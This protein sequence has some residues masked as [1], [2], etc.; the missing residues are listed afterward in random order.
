[1]QDGATVQNASV[2]LAEN[3]VSVKVHSRATCTEDLG[4]PACISVMD[5]T[6]TEAFKLDSTSAF[7]AGTCTVNVQSSAAVAARAISTSSTKFSK[8][9]AMGGVQGNTASLNMVA[10]CPSISD[11]W[12]NAMPT[13][14]I[15]AGC[16]SSGASRSG[17]YSV[18]PGSSGV[19]TFCGNNTLGG[20]KVT[21]NPGLYIVKDGALTLSAS[22]VIANGVSFYFPSTNST[23]V[24]KGKE[25]NSLK[26]PTSG[27]Y[28]GLLMFSGPEAGTRS[29]TIGS[30]DKTTMEG[31][32]H[33]PNWNLTLDST[34]DWSTVA[35]SKLNI[36]TKTFF[37]KSI[38][39]LNLKP[40]TTVSPSGSTDKVVYLDQ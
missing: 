18:T 22:T 20:S 33:A 31:I 14:D 38:S 28:K 19:Y 9:C 24:Y 23:I 17:T 26:A 2:A 21:L 3:G 30:A 36:V 29:V 34:S 1:M 37:G 4:P 16:N 32:I 5:P 39:K 27:P 11:P 7:N 40:Y 12:A 13:V 6:A 15:P 8:I 25:G 10:G 35:D